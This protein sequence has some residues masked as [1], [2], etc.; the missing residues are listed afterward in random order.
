LFK[1]SRVRFGPGTQCQAD[2]GYQ[3]MCHLHANSILPKKRSRKHPLGRQE[4]RRNHMISATRCLVE[5]IIRALKIFRILA[6]K[7]RNRR[8]RFCLRFNL[9]AALHNLN[10]SFG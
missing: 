4:K 10:L 2:T 5:N 1:D 9:I 8:R 7:Y 3:G 6:E